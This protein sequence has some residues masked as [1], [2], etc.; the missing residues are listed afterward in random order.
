MGMERVVSLASVGFRL[1]MYQIALVGR[2][3]NFDGI[4]KVLKM[5]WEI[6]GYGV[7]RLPTDSPATGALGAVGCGSLNRAADVCFDDWWV[8]F[9]ADVSDLP[10]DN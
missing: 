8:M 10:T 1:T 4:N 9:N 7:Y 6:L 5:R 3:A 2:V